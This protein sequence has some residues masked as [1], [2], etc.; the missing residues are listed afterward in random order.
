MKRG[1]SGFKLWLNRY[2]IL[3]IVSESLTV[4][5]YFKGPDSSVPTGSVDIKK[6]KSVQRDGSF[7]F[8]HKSNRIYELQALDDMEAQEWEVK[9]QNSIS[10]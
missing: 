5:K 10:T 7:I 8:L 1:E 4:L 2:F 3:Q 6:I 9:L